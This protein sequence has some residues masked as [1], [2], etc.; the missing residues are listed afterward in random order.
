MTTPEVQCSGRCRSRLALPAAAVFLVSAAILGLQLALMRCLA[1]AGWYHFSYL[2]ISTALLGFGASGTLLTLVGHVLERRFVQWAAALTLAFGLS[3]TLSFRAAQ[4]LPLDPQYA[5]YSARQA[6]LMLAYHILFLVPFFLGAA[7]IGLS[8]MH[9]RHGVHA[10][11]GAS[12]LGSGAGSLLMIL[13]MYVLP[14]ARLL[15]AVSAL[16][17][18][19]AGIWTACIAHSN[20]QGRAAPCR[21]SDAPP[22]LRRIRTALVVAIAASA[23]LLAVGERVWPLQPRIDQYK[24]LSVVRRWEAEGGARHLLSRH[25]PRARLDVYESPRFHYTLF[26]SLTTTLTPPSQLMILADGNP[27][28]AVLRISG[29]EEAAILDHTPMSL[30]YR[31]RDRPRVLLLGETGGMNVWLA[32]RWDASGVTVV[33][34]NPQVIELLGGP[35][36]SMGGRVLSL[37][38]VVAAAADPR[39]FLETTRERY[40]IIQIV[41]AEEMPAG[42][43]GMLSLHEDFL[44]TREGLALC[45][46]RLRP[47]GLLAIT[48]GIQWP[49]RDN[50]KILATVTEAL[51]SLGKGPAVPRRMQGAG[52]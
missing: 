36:A 49:P 19:A 47:N 31:L 35:L 39:L 1:V 8:L 38:G 40:D 2:V 14:E 21:Q 50:V 17:L 51:E 3:V 34:R 24:M 52:A 48:R 46:R 32:Q 27:A 28:G 45:L 9:F 22:E 44:L 33:Q 5:L 12:M 7:V 10:V 37:P 41:Q 30:P 15:Y 43:A 11:Y 20:S 4:A 29:P 6:G 23:V 26:A 16:A 42:G 25:S 18:A 13:L